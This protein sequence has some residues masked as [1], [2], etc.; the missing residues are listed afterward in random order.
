MR[1]ALAGA[2]ALLLVPPGGAWAKTRALPRYGAF[3]Y[4]NLC[5]GRQ[6]GDA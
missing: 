2:L 5:W 6:S 4:S 1:R 3:T